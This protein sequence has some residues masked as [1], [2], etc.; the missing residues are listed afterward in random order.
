MMVM[1]FFICEGKVSN[2]IFLWLLTTMVN[3]TKCKK[4]EP[5]QPDDCKLCYNFLGVKEDIK[6]I[7]YYFLF[8]L[9]LFMSMF[10]F[11]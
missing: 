8:V 1:M 4:S 2:F 6:F 5:L 7:L 10:Y 9:F 3:N 11:H